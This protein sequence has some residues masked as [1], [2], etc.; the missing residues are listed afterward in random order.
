[1]EKKVNVAKEIIK[2]MLKT[3]VIILIIV[4]FCGL[5]FYVINPKFS[6]GVC[7]QF[8]W[9]KAEISCYELVY[10]RSKNNSDLYNLIVKLGNA[11]EFQK[12]NDYIDKLQKLDDYNTFCLTMDNSV[13]DGYNNGKI[14]AKNVGLLYGTNEYITSRKV[15]NLLKLGKYEDAYAL[16]VQSKTTDH[17][18]ELV[19][20]N[21]I[22][23]L[24]ASEVSDEIKANYFTKVKADFSGYLQNKLANLPTTSQGAVQILVAYTTLKIQ[25]TN[26]I[27]ALKTSPDDIA[28]SYVNWQAALNV[29]NN[30]V[31]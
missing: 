15:I 5:G 13:L 1:M 17:A 8:G 23:N 28:D 21:Y 24:Y 14:Q 30:L 25:Y 19:V 11:K 10:A 12:Q 26:Y 9:Q 3:M 22:E 20:Y 18:Y 6:A 27:M 31:K 2:T 7:Q 16:V 29:Y 4:V